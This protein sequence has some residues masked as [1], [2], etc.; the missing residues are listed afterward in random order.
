MNIVPL[1]TRTRFIAAASICMMPVIGAQGQAPPALPANLVL[2]KLVGH[3]KMTGQVLGKPATYD[4]IARRI[5]DNRYV[6][7]HM[8]DVA[9]PAA[10]EAIVSIG[11]DTVATKVLVHWIDSFGAAYSVPAGSGT[12]SGDTI[13]FQ[14]PYPYGPFR[15][16]FVFSQQ[17]WSW[18]FRIEA[19]DGHGAWK[20]FANYTVTPAR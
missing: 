12:A 5:L 1:F 4:L 15:D 11:E 6:E 14:I 10:Y 20:L 8:K 18:E 16:T 13:E 9:R 19:S 3:W 2:E 17:S 7:L